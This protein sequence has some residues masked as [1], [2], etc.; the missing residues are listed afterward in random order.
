MET[1]ARRGGFPRLARSVTA[2]SG[3]PVPEIRRPGSKQAR[4]FPEDEVI[5]LGGSQ[6]P[7]PFQASDLRRDR[8]E[9]PLAPG[10]PP[11]VG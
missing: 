2:V 7:V 4:T 6:A 8:L 3:P 5:L 1:L 10:Q 9:P 11:T